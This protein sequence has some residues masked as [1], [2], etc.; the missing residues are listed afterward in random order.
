VGKLPTNQGGGNGA[1]P[2]LNLVQHLLIN[3]ASLDALDDLA[4]CG[5]GEWVEY[6]GLPCRDVLVGYCLGLLGYSIHL[7]WGLVGESV[8][9]N[10]FSFPQIGISICLCNTLS[11]AVFGVA[12]PWLRLKRPLALTSGRVGW[13]M[14]IWLC[15]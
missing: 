1:V 5:G 4:P 13:W 10:I 6:I 8:G 14:L 2:Y 7:V 3:L 11:V 9:F 12:L 15:S